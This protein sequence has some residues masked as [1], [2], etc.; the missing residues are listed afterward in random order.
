MEKGTITLKTKIKTMILFKQFGNLGRLGN[1]MFQWAAM[2]GMSKKYGT[3]FRVPAWRYSEFFM[4]PP[5]AALP[6]DTSTIEAREPYFHYA[7]EHFDKFEAAFKNSNVNL[8]GYF[9]TPLYWEKDQKY[10]QER[11]S[12]T[13]AF[14]RSVK[15]K[16]IHVFNKPTIAISVRRGDFVGNPNHYLLPIN[17]YIGALYNNFQD[18]QNFN[19]VIFSD[20]LSYC[21]VHFQCL[22]NVTFADGLSDIEQLCLMSMMENFILSNSTFSWWGGYLGQKAYS[23]VIRPAHHFAGQQSIDCNIKDH[24]P[25]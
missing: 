6:S 2:L 24:Y 14:A 17:Y 18:L 11:M 23:K 3:E 12:F 10:I 25:H 21:K 4:Y 16:F 9:Q 20:D 7:G 1:Q 5:T 8:Y 19:V 15:E 13:H 22:D